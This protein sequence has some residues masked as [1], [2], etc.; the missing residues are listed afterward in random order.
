MMADRNDCGLKRL[1]DEDTGSAGRQ[2]PIDTTVVT[3]TCITCGAPLVDGICSDLASARQ[4]LRGRV[5]AGADLVAVI[6][7]MAEF[8][9]RLK[10]IHESSF[11]AENNGDASEDGQTWAE[12][13]E[14]QVAEL[15]AEIG[16]L[17]IGGDT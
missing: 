14:Q 8:S 16:E 4:R 7:A 15:A 2:P 12:L 11:Y 6:K 5:I 13:Y 3:D 9:W 17:R 1:R 10:E